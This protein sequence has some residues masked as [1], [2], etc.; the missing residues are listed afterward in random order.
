MPLLEEYPQGYWEG[1][2]FILPTFPPLQQAAFQAPAPPPPVSP[3]LRAR[4][5]LV[6]PGDTGDGMGTP[7]PDQGLG[8]APPESPAPGQDPSGQSSSG[9]YSATSLAPVMGN[10]LGLAFGPAGKFGGGLLGSIMDTARA[11]K[12]L[13]EMFG[14]NPPGYGRQAYDPDLSIFDTFIDS[15]FGVL[16]FGKDAEDQARAQQR[17]MA[18]VNYEDPNTYQVEVTPEEMQ[19]YGRA[20]G[21][22]ETEPP[23]GTFD[24]FSPG[25]WS[26]DPEGNVGMGGISGAPSTAA[27]EATGMSSDDW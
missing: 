14:E 22:Y 6:W 12:A 9:L 3:L 18:V 19:A 1:N 10:V 25:G 2:Q 15:M 27:D 24:P 8:E 4:P 17:H 11:E 5:L 21:G 13:A 26:D 23:T 7:D 16:G 20:W